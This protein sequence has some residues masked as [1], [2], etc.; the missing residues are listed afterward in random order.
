VDSIEPVWLFG[1]IALACGVFLGALI[2]RLMNPTAD[3]VSQLKTDLERERTEMERYKA[4]VNSHFNKTSDLVK[5]LTQDYVKVYQHLAEGAQALSDSPEFTQVLEQPRGRVLISMQDESTAAPEADT[6]ASASESGDPVD[7]A[8][9]VA[10]DTSEQAKQEDAVAADSTDA[11]AAAVEADA[12]ADENKAQDA[13][14]RAGR[15][16]DAEEAD[17]T[18]DGNA[19]TDEPARDYAES[20]EKSVTEEADAS[21]AVATEETA[22]ESSKKA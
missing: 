10:V 3:D 1:A 16:T 6:V 11:D 13:D 14:T 9:N 21:S 19:D 5:E 18:A 22:T 17:K 7:P 4:S 2:N 20:P 15:E 12:V 8:D